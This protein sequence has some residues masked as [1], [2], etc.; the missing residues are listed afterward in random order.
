M[1]A[2][3]HHNSMAFHFEEKA[4]REALH[5]R[6]TYFRMHHLKGEGTSR[7]NLYCGIYR[8]SKAQAKV[9][10]NAFV[11]GERFL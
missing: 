7:H 2:G 3:N 4:V 8:Q 9:R 6:P 1:H 5:S 10:V 11:P